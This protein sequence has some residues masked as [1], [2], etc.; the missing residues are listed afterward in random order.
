MPDV[1]QGGW[2]DNEM[3]TPWVPRRK[4]Q[5]PEADTV[6]LERP[7]HTQVGLTG[8]Q[9]LETRGG[10]GVLSKTGKK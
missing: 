2:L 10:G 8:K 7:C 5:N 4:Q 6:P 9:N 3:T 1:T